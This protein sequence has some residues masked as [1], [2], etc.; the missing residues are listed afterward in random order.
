MAKGGKHQLNICDRWNY[1]RC[2]RLNTVEIIKFINKTFTFLKMISRRV[3]SPRFESEGG[4]YEFFRGQFS[5]HWV[6]C[7]RSFP[8]NY[9]KMQLNNTL[10]VTREFNKRKWKWK[11]HNISLFS[12][13][14]S[15]ALFH[16]E[17]KRF[18]LSTFYFSFLFI[19]RIK[20]ENLISCV[21]A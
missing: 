19:T 15:T 10:Q 5:R 20:S 13:S 17:L 6:R 8:E 11:F 12:W 16:N 21:D 18:S 9:T 1:F 14:F 7:K 4:K 2:E 3:F